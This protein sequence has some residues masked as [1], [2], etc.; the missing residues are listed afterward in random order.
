M[1]LQCPQFRELLFPAEAVGSHGLECEAG[2]GRWLV[3]EPLLSQLGPELHGASAA[4]GARLLEVFYGWSCPAGH[5][6]WAL[7]PGGLSYL[8]GLGSPHTHWLV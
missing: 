5:P 1:G 3:P 4:Q 7:L 6:A 2:W 8:L